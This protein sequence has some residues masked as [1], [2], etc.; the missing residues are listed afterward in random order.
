MIY[1]HSTQAP[2]LTKPNRVLPVGESTR[3]TMPSHTRC[4]KQLI[5]SVI[6]DPETKITFWCGAWA[7]LEASPSRLREAVV[8]NTP[9]SERKV[10]NWP[11]IIV[12]MEASTHRSEDESGSSRAVF[13]QS[14][15]RWCDPRPLWSTYSSVLG[16]HTEPQI[17]PGVVPSVCDC[18][19]MVVAPDEQVAAWMAAPALC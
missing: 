10:H 15:C 13:H 7:A 5:G 17:A 4:F 19:W 3:S 9:H 6:C 14:E 1:P 12:L 11:L 16:Q 8:F 2:P 18:A